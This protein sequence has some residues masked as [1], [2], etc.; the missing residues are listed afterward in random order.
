MYYICII[1][2]LYMYYICIINVL[3]LYYICGIFDETN[4]DENIQ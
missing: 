2:V 3:Y 1:Y 4:F